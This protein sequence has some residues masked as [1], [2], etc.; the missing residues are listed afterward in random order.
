MKYILSILVF[1]NLANADDWTTRYKHT[2]IIEKSEE[3]NSKEQNVENFRETD[4]KNENV[5]ETLGELKQMF[6][7]NGVKQLNKDII[8]PLNY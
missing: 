3:N 8:Q 5:S 6:N 2:N 7:K 4:Q 1:L